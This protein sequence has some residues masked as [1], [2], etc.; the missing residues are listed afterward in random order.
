MFKIEK[1]EPEKRF[2]ADMLFKKKREKMEQSDI[3]SVKAEEDKKKRGTATPK[4]APDVLKKKEVGDGKQRPTEPKGPPP[5]RA[6]TDEG[7][8]SGSHFKWEDRS[9][10]SGRSWWEQDRRGAN[11]QCFH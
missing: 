10:K 8:S 7:Q 6:K 1:K 9:E 5:K 11:G 4:I 2:S 3:E